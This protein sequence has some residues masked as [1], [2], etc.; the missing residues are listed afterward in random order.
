MQILEKANFLSS[1]SA[2]NLLSCKI[3]IKNQ[4]GNIKD[5][6]SELS[7]LANDTILL[8]PKLKHMIERMLSLTEL[9][10]VVL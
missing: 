3:Y 8:A 2:A 10:E 7:K 9:I 4:F 5:D 1:S 6:I